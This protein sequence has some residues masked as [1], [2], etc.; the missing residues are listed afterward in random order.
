MERGEFKGRWGRQISLSKPS[1]WN[2]EV[3]LNDA[4]RRVV[5]DR[6]REAL[7]FMRL[8]YAEV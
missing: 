3:P 7:K 5:Q 8:P 2:D 4:E 6:M 1:Q